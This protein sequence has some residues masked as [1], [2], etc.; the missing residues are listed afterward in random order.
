MWGIHVGEG[1][2]PV[3]IV[4][5]VEVGIRRQAELAAPAFHEAA[6]E[7]VADGH[8]IGLLM[9]KRLVH[10]IEF[11]QAVGAALHRCQ[12]NARRDGCE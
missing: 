10:P 7:E 6:P 3:Q 12:C 5:A 1:D 4:V 2:D 8:A 9:P 11:G